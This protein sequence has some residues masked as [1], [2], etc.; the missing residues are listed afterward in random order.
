MHSGSPGCP[1]LARSI[2]RILWLATH[3]NIS[4]FRTQF[5]VKFVTEAPSWSRSIYIHTHDL[6]CPAQG[7]SWRHRSCI[8]EIFSVVVHDDPKIVI[9]V[10]Q[11]N[12]AS[13]LLPPIPG[14]NLPYCIHGY[15]S[16]PH[17]GSWNTT[18]KTFHWFECCVVHLLRNVAFADDTCAQLQM[19]KWC[20]YHFDRSRVIGIIRFSNCDHAAPEGW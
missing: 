13:R 17:Q 16:V 3:R 11:L 14:E 6:Y 1:Q 20:T 7:R 4:P 10:L 15:S 18:R 5:F 2:S 12:G 19:E 8:H 9:K